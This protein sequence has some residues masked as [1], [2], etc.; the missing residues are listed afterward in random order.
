[1]ERETLLV[2][3]Q[4]V[5]GKEDPGVR[6]GGLQA[7]EKG[8]LMLPG[9]CPVGSLVELSDGAVAMVVADNPA[10]PLRPVVRLVLDQAGDHPD[11]SVVVDLSRGGPSV[12]YRVGVTDPE[13]RYV[14]GVPEGDT[15]IKEGS[16]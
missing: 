1:M 3:R 8:T 11:D 2:E 14:R 13:V 5:V 9:E 12:A 15:A 7:F 16:S 10:T 6:T 4:S